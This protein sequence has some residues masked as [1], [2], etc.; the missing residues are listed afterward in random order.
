MKVKIYEGGYLPKRAHFDD[1]GLDF[2]SPEDFTI[3]A[4]G[5]YLADLK[6][7][8][9]LPIGTYGYMTSKSG[10]MTQHGVVCAGGV[11]DS[12]FRGT[13]KVRMEN[14]GDTPYTFHKGDKVVQMVIHSIMMEDVYAVDELDP[15]D[16]GRNMSGWGSSGK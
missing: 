1:A 9:Q 14:H 12:G 15:A 10:L 8:V 5:A 7:A 3:P 16:S 4:H 2:R 6:V 13:I 11:V